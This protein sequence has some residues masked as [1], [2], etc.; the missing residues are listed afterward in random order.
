MPLDAG[1]HNAAE[2]G[3]EQ[4]MG[5]RDG[6]VQFGAFFEFIAIHVRLIEQFGGGLGAFAPDG[7]QFKNES[8][9][10]ANRKFNV[11]SRS[12][13]HMLIFAR[14]RGPCYSAPG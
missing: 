9:R 10:A 13:L 3:L 4:T 8:G 1:E 2:M 12:I 6:V 14:R 5:L 7:I 11:S